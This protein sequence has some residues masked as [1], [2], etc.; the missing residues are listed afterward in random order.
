MFRKFVMFYKFLFCKYEN[1]LKFANLM[2]FMVII[3]CNIFTIY[4]YSNNG[5]MQLLK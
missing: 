2:A 5:V 4:M 3:F 1:R